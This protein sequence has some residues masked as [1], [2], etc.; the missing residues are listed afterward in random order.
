MKKWARL[1]LEP[2]EL[3]KGILFVRKSYKRALDS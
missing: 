2:G 3:E 1:T